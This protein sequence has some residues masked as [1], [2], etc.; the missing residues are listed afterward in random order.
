MITRLKQGSNFTA[1]ILPTSF[2]FMLNGSL[3]CLNVANWHITVWIIKITFC[4]IFLRMT[5]SIFNIWGQIPPSQNSVCHEY[6][7]NKCLCHKC[8]HLR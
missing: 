3:C 4:V 1:F 6:D 5:N 8:D 7:K 2:F